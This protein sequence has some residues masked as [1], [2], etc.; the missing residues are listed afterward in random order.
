[1]AHLDLPEWVPEGGSDED[2]AR[3]GETEIP[4]R[5]LRFV[6]ADGKAWI[7]VDGYVGRE[8]SA[9]LRK[10]FCFVRGLLALEG[11]AS[12]EAYL[13]D[14]SVEAELVPGNAAE[15]YCFAGEAPW[16]ATFDSW[17]TGA[18]GNSAPEVRPL[19]WRDEDGPSIELLA[20]DFNWE[21]Y[22]SVLNDAEIGSLP[23]K[24]FARFAS[25]AKLP[26]RAEFVD[27][28]GEPVARAT[29]VREEGWR[30]HLLLA[31]EDVL[32]AYCRE[33]G[34]EWGWIVW[35]EREVH[36]PEP[37]SFSDVPPWMREVRLQGLDRFSRVAS[38]AGL[39]KD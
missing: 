19:G 29:A 4:D 1:M 25:L 3:S 34:G 5:L 15:Y 20:V 22:H 6:D 31:R 30:G 28:G 9:S 32:K 17:A 23:S 12:I 8:P 33:R 7:A 36:L 39:Q 10:V 35:G 14:H 26:D 2:W 27:P 11:W 37:A 16:S 24:A 21:G 38:L 18:D 13:A